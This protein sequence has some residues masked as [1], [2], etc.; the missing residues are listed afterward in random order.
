MTKEGQQVELPDELSSD[1]SVE[2]PDTTLVLMH[3]VLVTE[4]QVEEVPV[5]VQAGDETG[6]RINQPRLAPSG[7]LLITLALT[8]PEAERLVFA[9]EKGSLYMAQEPEDAPEGGTR[10][11]TRAS[12]Y[13]STEPTSAR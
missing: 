13:E 10:I 1:L 11:Q 4:V 9:I 7:N 12:V 2:T 6:T 8:T 5:Q 3:K